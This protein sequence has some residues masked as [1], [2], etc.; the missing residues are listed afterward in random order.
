MQ[1]NVSTSGN[2]YFL[3]WD[4][5]SSFGNKVYYTIEQS[6]DN[7]NWIYIKDDYDMFK[8]DQIAIP[9]LAS[10]TYYYRVKAK[11]TETVI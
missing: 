9:A 3:N 4:S 6:T 8:G 1:L 5:V 2:N 10:G 11:E 7:T